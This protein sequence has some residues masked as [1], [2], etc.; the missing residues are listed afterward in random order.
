MLAGFPF[1]NDAQQNSRYHIAHSY[2]ELDVF[3]VFMGKNTTT[4]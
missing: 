4:D 1:E 3:V 2:R